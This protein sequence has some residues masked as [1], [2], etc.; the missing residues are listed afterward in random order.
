[1]LKY[2]EGNPIPLSLIVFLSYF[3]LVVLSHFCQFVLKHNY[4]L[5][6]LNV[7]LDKIVAM[8]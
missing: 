7:V 1:M 5:L 4:D 3:H 8:A 6:Y 2:L